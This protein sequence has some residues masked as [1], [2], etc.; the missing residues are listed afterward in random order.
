MPKRSL[1]IDSNLRRD[2]AFLMSMFDK[3]KQFAADNPDKV[4]QGV[5]KVGDAID[6]KTGNKHAEHVDK[7]QEA[8]RNHLNK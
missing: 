4:D 2:G 6:A 7:A 5:D 3:A 1:L 8:A